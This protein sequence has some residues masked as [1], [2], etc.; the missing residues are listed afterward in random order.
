M[1]KP[2]FVSIA[3]N[4][5]GSSLMLSNYCFY[6][7][8]RKVKDIKRNVPQLGI[9]ERAWRDSVLQRSGWEITKLLAVCAEQRFSMYSLAQAIPRQT[10]EGNKLHWLGRRGEQKLH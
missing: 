9:D 5:F 8:K 2:S 3:T 1:G 4:R 6:L 7:D 10:S